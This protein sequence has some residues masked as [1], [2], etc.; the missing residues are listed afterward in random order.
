LDPYIKPAQE[1]IREYMGLLA[2]DDIELHGA[3][4]LKSD[5]GTF[6]ILNLVKDL[7]K[8][9]GPICQIVE[10]RVL[11]VGKVFE[12]FLKPEF[13]PLVPPS[14]EDYFPGKRELWEKVYSLPDAM[15]AEFMLAYDALD[16]SLLLESLK[17]ITNGLSLHQ[18]NN[19]ADLMLGSRSYVDEIIKY[20]KI[21]RV[22]H[23]SIRLNTPNAAS[24]H[25]FFQFLEQT[26]RAAEIP[27]ITL[28][29]DMIPQFEGVF[30]SLF[31]RFRDAQ[32]GG[33]YKEGLNSYVFRGFRSLKHFTFADSKEEP[34]LQA[35]DVVVSSMYRY[36]LN[37][38]NDKP[39]S[40]HLTEI[41]RIF[42]DVNNGMPVIMRT[43]VSS[44]FADKLYD[45]VKR[46]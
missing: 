39:S 13:N 3:R 25:M 35:A 30:P 38:Y 16:R 1:H 15:L 20:N 10:K 43:S 24:F 2:Q 29:H 46:L 22:F 32:H 8:A 23:D 4:L 34:L 12:L 28:V 41:A 37:V 44:R 21:G 17:N 40:S 45:S 6:G 42:L 36:A 9:C 31:E 5:L 18:E 14:F 7:L 33:V 26:G 27:T 11:L 19:L